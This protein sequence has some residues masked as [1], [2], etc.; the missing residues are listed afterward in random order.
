MSQGP[1]E[2]VSLHKDAYKTDNAALLFLDTRGHLV[3]TLRP[4]VHTV[5]FIPAC[6]LCSCPLLRSP[7]LCLSPT[8]CRAALCLCPSCISTVPALCCKLSALVQSPSLPVSLSPALAWMFQ[9][10]VCQHF[11]SMS[12][13]ISLSLTVPF[14]SQHPPAFSSFPLCHTSLLSPPLVHLMAPFITSG[15]NQ[16]RLCL[17][18][19]LPR[20]ALFSPR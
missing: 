18:P 6:P 15:C 16:E 3:L 20:S 2:S 13:S 4:H 7:S 12:L 8:P 1:R 5:P 10:L 11:S 14:P 9:L 19:C 17:C